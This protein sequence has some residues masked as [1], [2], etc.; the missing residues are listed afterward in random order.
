[1]MRPKYPSPYPRIR[2]DRGQRHLCGPSLLPATCAAT[3]LAY[4]LRPA[5]EVPASCAAAL[6]CC[7]RCRPCLL[8]LA[9]DDGEGRVEC[10][11]CI[12]KLRDAGTSSTPVLRPKMQQ[13]PSVDTIPSVLRCPK[14]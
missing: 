8:L 2:G 10:A 1:V 6:A 5:P 11:V 12:N 3:G 7:L 9:R 14:M 13:P 4:C